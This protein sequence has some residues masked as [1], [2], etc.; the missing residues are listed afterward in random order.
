MSN[1]IKR[2]KA[3][4]ELTHTER[5]RMFKWCQQQAG[6]LFGLSDEDQGMKYL[7]VGRSVLKFEDMK[8]FKIINQ[9]G[10]VLPDVKVLPDLKTPEAMTP[11]TNEALDAKIEELNERLKQH[12]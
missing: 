6:I 2:D 9:T 12:D 8:A 10:E 1:V 7:E 4:V 5:V 11:M 3:N